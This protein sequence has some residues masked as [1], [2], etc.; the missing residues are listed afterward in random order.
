MAALALAAAA[1]LSA[2]VRR[3]RRVWMAGAIGL[4]G[5]ALSFGPAL[6]GYAWLQSHVPL[7]EGLRAAARWGLLPLTAVAILA[8]FAVA[9]W[10]RRARSR[11]YRPAAALALLAVLTLEALRAPMTFAGAPLV[12]ALTTCSARKPQVVLVELPLFAGT[13]VSENARYMVHSTRHFR[14][15][16]NGYSGFEPDAFRQRADRW[17]RFPEADVLQ[18]DAAARRHPRR[19]APTGPRRFTGAG[20]GR[21]PGAGAGG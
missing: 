5:L 7:F 20:R 17:R 10:E 3:D 9:A 15:L 11:T 14:P 1:L 13:S 18:R 6:P 12:P 2:D 8:G 21:Q 16:V 19:R 4:V